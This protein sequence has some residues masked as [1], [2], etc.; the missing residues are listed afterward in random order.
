MLSLKLGGKLEIT[1]AY[2]TE[3]KT[4]GVFHSD[5]RSIRERRRHC[6]QSRTRKCWWIYA[7]DMDEALSE[8]EKKADLIQR[9]CTRWKQDSKLEN[10]VFCYRTAASHSFSADLSLTSTPFSCQKCPAPAT[11]TLA[12]RDAG[13]ALSCSD[14]SRIFFDE[15]KIS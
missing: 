3:R 4:D 13:S 10:L 6:I 14:Q 11:S 12:K 9:E 1:Y 8:D 7:E 5:S 15:A 2:S